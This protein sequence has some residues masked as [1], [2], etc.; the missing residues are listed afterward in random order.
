[1][2]EPEQWAF[3]TAGVAELWCLFPVP[4]DINLCHSAFYRDGGED[5]NSFLKPGLEALPV[6]LHG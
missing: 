5:S 3:R 6:T 2:E 4:R 1:M